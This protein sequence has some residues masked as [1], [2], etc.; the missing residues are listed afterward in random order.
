MTLMF[1]WPN[2]GPIH[3]DTGFKAP[4]MAK[5]GQKRA[6]WPQKGVI[7]IK[8]FQKLHHTSSNLTLEPGLYVRLAKFWAQT[9]RCGF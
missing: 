4:K 2:F 8:N 3:K 6:K 1:I 9:K 5:I 7:D